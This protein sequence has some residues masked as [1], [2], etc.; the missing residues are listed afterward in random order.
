MTIRCSL[1][2]C[3]FGHNAWL[4]PSNGRHLLPIHSM[5]SFLLRKI[6]KRA[7]LD[8]FAFYRIENLLTR[9]RDKPVFNRVDKKEITVTLL[10]NNELFNAIPAGNIT[11][12]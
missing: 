3:D 9:R 5:G 6:H 11:A 1:V 8:F 4:H 10:T 2:K 7:F 12:D